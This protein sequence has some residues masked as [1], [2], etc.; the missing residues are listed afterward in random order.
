MKEREVIILGSGVAGLT[1]AIYNARAELKPLVLTGM[2][3]GGQIAT[4]T[5]V[6][7]W[8]GE[9]DGIQGPELVQRMKRQA[10]K[11]GAEVK[12]ERATEF[13]P[14]K[15]G[16]YTIKTDS[17]AYRTDAAIVATGASARWLGLPD[18]EK[19]RSNGVHTCATCDGAFYKDKAV[20]VVG[21][22]DAACEDAH[23]M[24]RFANKVTMLVRRDVMRASVAMRER[25]ERDP[26]IEIKYNHGIGRYL[27]DEKGLNGVVLKNNKT[28]KETE[29]EVDGVFLAIGHVP[30]TKIFEGKL[31]MDEV[32]YL[33]A[34]KET[35]TNLPGV[36]AA[37]D[38]ADHVFR[39]AVT[40][41][42]TGAAAA[43]K[44]ERYLAEKKHRTTW[45]P[46]SE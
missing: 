16:T 23:F 32:K 18:E 36:F 20:V 41:A 4:T 22:G 42:G 30:N 3:D 28:G 46:L 19:Y 9:P 10:E 8:P 39:Q 33:V 37:G 12:T 2:E 14:N 43:I 34:N 13:I 44:A 1:A 17:D 29:M 15:D 45:V 6:E 21:G 35:E 11:F 27:G 40:A 26:K 38:V 31:D 24:T 25:M 7:N 5:V